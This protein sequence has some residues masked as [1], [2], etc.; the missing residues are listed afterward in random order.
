MEILD[1]QCEKFLGGPSVA[2]SERVHVTINRKG[3]IFLNQ[4]AHKL[5]GSPLAVYLYYNREKDMIILERT[6]ALRARDAFLL[7]EVPGTGRCI[8][9][10][11]FCKHFR[12]RVEGTVRFHNLEVDAV[13][14]MFL[15][16][17]DTVNVSVGPRTRKKKAA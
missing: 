15:K 10:N 6:D 9:A 5:M 4:K 11:S 1:R 13:G 3:K 7:R 14:R 2:Y 8:W 12:I 17:R 16:L